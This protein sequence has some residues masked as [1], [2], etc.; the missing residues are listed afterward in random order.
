MWR[1]YNVSKQLVSSLFEQTHTQ[2]DTRCVSPLWSQ[3]SVQEQ[4]DCSSWQRADS[5]LSSCV[6]AGEAVKCGLIVSLR[7]RPKLVFSF[8]FLQSAFPQSSFPLSSS[9]DFIIWSQQLIYS[10]HT[11]KLLLFSWIFFSSSPINKAVVL[12]VAWFSRFLVFFSSLPPTLPPFLSLSQCN[13]QDLRF[14]APIP[15]APSHPV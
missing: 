11:H 2:C 12:H 5:R 14:F 7:P 3:L 4:Q 6:S 9:S 1:N 8:L 10:V 13:I 15:V